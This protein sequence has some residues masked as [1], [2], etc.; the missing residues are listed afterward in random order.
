[1]MRLYMS[2]CSELLAILPVHIGQFTQQVNQAVR[3]FHNPIRL[4][5]EEYVLNGYLGLDGIQV[6]HQ[7][8]RL[9]D[10]LGN[11]LREL[12]KIWFSGGFLCGD[13][14]ANWHLFT[15]LFRGVR[16]LRRAD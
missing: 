1:M 6:G 14:H 9:E 4:L 2:G 11:D 3:I 8:L 15:F 7:A 16:D 10:C 13:K 5:S 12:H